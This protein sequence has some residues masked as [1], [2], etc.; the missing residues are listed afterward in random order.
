[1]FIGAA[2]DSIFPFHY[3]ITEYN[4]QD[5]LES[6]K[7]LALSAFCVIIIRKAICENEQ[8]RMEGVH[9]DKREG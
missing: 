4:W 5:K 9:Y 1:M 2:S 7:L 6:A 8:K 3:S